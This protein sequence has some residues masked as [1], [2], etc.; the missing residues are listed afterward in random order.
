MWAE[1]DS[2]QL[3]CCYGDAGAGREEHEVPERQDA[4]EGT[5][6]PGQIFLNSAEGGEQYVRER[7]GKVI[8]SPVVSSGAGSIVR[9]ASGT[10]QAGRDVLFVLEV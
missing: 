4:V 2:D 5:P 1:H 7:L 10:V 3:L 9:R 6:Q 8:L